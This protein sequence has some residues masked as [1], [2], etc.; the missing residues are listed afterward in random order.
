MTFTPQP[1]NK[2]ETKQ[3]NFP[4]PAELVDR[5]DAL[6]EK[7]GMKRSPLII[8]M[9]EYALE[10]AEKKRGR[11]RPPKAEAVEDDPPPEAPE[12]VDI[13]D[14]DDDDGISVDEAEQFGPRRRVAM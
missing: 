7:V 6:A 14:D 2:A 12:P 3:I 13:G 4:A 9:M 5:V 1:D 11:G 8:Q 10:N